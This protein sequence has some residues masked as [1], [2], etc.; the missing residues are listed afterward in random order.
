MYRSVVN[1]ESSAIG[2]IH[3]RPLAVEITTRYSK[4]MDIEIA[5]FHC[6][7]FTSTGTGALAV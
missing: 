5:I 3:V 1:F 2:F 4:A 7:K 6:E